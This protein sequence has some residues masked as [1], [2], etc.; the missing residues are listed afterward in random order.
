MTDLLEKAFNKA[1]RL[2][3]A[4][5]DAL[6]ERLLEEL[7]SEERWEKAFEGAEDVLSNLADEALDEH[8]RGR[9]EPLDPDNL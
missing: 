7:E 8:R 6:A 1:S 4:E 9:T 3:P 5:Q 2:T